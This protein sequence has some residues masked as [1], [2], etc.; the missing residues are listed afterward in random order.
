MKW[1]LRT[2]DIISTYYHK[3]GLLMLVCLRL[4]Y[5]FIVFKR[6]SFK[7]EIEIEIESNH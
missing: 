6:V 3:F 5:Y 1:F 2:T 7:I 4:L